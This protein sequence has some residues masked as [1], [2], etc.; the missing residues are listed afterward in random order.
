MV[1]EYDVSCG[2][3]GS[4]IVSVVEACRVNF[5]TCAVC[6]LLAVVDTAAMR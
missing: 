6:F 1:C 5:M 2:N 3:G 4:M